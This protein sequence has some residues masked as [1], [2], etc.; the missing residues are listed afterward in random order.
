MFSYW[1]IMLSLGGCIAL[2]IGSCAQ[3]VIHLPQCYDFLS[4]LHLNPGVLLRLL[5]KKKKSEKFSKYKSFFFS[6]S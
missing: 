6:S 4:N 2:S 3:N 1:P 5:V